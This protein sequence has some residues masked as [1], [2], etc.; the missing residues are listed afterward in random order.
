MIRVLVVDDDHL[1]RAG[2]VELL[3]ADPEIAVAGHADSGT[4]AVEMVQLTA[5]DVVLM[6]IRMPNGDGI[7]AT[8]RIVATAPATRVLVLTTFEQDDYLFDALDAG[9]SGFLLKRTRPE[10]LLDAIHVVADGDALLDPA[11]TRRVIDR[12][13][14]R[15][16]IDPPEV[17][18]SILTARERDVLAGITRGLSN[19]EIA[20]ELIIEES[21]V[22]THVKK[23]F[24]KLGL[25]DR[26]Q[27]VIYAYENGLAQTGGA[28]SLGPC[29]PHR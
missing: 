10:D 1:M 18:L 28:C 19:A 21:T 27:A 6:D 29:H 12:L 15:P 22:R 24:Q 9:A 5:P 16:S 4:R 3:G 25:R 20:S 26:V 8:R 11:V 13:G 2:L 7:E 17:R 14:R 23:I